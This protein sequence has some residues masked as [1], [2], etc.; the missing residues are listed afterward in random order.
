M[1]SLEVS[2]R[3][4]HS[5]AAVERDPLGD[6]SLAR[7]SDRLKWFGRD[8][9]DKLRGASVRLPAVPTGAAG[10]NADPVSGRR[11]LIPPR[12]RMGVSA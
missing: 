6:R 3:F 9:V 1:L 5:E 12:W 11:T 4:G 7:R 10:P 2:P 8:A